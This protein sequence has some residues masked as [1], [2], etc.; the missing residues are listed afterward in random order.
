MLLLTSMF[1]GMFTNFFIGTF[2]DMVVVHTHLLSLFMGVLICIYSH[3]SWMCS[4]EYIVI[5]R[6]F[7]RIH[8]YSH[9]S[10]VCSYS[11]TFIVHGFVHIHVYTAV[12]VQTFFMGVF[13]QT[14][15]V[16]R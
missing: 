4:Y 6:G 1:V 13:I 5:V 3:C 14:T 10:W 15:F 8:M 2:I 7:I 11:C 16:D 9:C 12:H